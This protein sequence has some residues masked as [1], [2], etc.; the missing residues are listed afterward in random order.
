MSHELDMSNERA[1]MAYVGQVPWHGFGKVMTPDADAKT[2][3]VEA[4]MD[5]LA[6]ESVVKFENL[7]FISGNLDE[8]EYPGQKVIYRS[9]N[10]APLSI[11]TDKYK[12]VQP[13]QMIDFFANLIE[14]HG[15]KMETAGCLYGG[16]IFW[17][18]AQTCRG[19]DIGGGDIIKPY[20]LIVS[21]VD[22]KMATCV[23]LTSIRVVCWNTLR[24][25]IGSTG[26]KAIVRVPHSQFFDPTKAQIKAG[27]VE[28]VWEEFLKNTK[29]LTGIKVDKV[30]AIDILF[31]T[32]KTNW[33][34][35][36]GEELGREEIEDVS[37]SVKKIMSMYNET[38]IGGNLI[39]SKGTAW[40]FLNAVTQWCDYE[41][42]SVNFDKS[43]AFVRTHFKDRSNF[44]IKVANSLLELAR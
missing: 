27:L 24:M 32:M 29:I 3:K 10:L 31:A 19:E 26:N 22:G 28:G 8:Y 36:E 34:T 41:A 11:V 7:D 14:H 17:A 13:G 18:L 15:F 37:K 44:K 40:G 6:E 4:G 21:S 35:E 43:N 16:R 9:D 25:S 38:A 30:T 20:A 5:W 1:N 33:K 12:I 23:H 2:W 42:G 39:S